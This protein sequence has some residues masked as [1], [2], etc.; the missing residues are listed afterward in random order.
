MNCNLLGFLFN[1]VTLELTS[2]SKVDPN[3]PRI[4]DS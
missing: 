4:E 2:Q 1:E 3:K